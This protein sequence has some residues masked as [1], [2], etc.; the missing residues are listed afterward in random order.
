MISRADIDRLLAEDVPAGDLTT[1]ALGIG[2][3]S[4]RMVFTAPII[5]CMSAGSE[6][7]PGSTCGS[8]NASEPASVTRPRL[9]GCSRQT[10]QE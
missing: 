6:K 5:F 8:A 9:A 2:D 1:D 7:K 4:G 10:W 3:S